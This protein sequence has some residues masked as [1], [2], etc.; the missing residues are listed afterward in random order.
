MFDPPPPKNSGMPK[1]VDFHVIDPLHSEVHERLLN[2]ARWVKVRPELGWKMAPF[3]KLIKKER[4]REELAIRE[5]CDI[6]DAEMVE[7]IV[8]A[9]P[10]PNRTAIRWW[11]VKA[12]NPRK[13][14]QALGLS[15]SGLSDIISQTR[16]LLSR[17][18]RGC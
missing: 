12:D 8:R 7:K 4:G 9:L 1:Y 11:Y 15:L 17:S 14:A 10:E 6:L 3:W 16:S 13:A 18:L 2:W 5:P